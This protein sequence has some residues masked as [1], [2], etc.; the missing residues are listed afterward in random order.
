MSKWVEA[1][2]LPSNDG[3]VVLKFIHKH[4]F[5]RFRTTRS[6]ISDRG[7]HFINNPVRNFLAKNR[8]R[9]KVATVYPLG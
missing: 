9:H 4:I 6:M 7:T 5:T 8:V 3:K 2:A 1:V